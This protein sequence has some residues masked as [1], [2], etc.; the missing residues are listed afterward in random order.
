MKNKNLLNLLS[1]IATLVFVSCTNTPQ[2]NSALYQTG[3]INALLDGLYNGEVNFKQLKE[4]GDFGIGTFNTLDGEMLGFDGQFYQVKSDG[5]AY[6]VNDSLKTPFAVVT[7]FNKDIS[8]QL[9]D[10]LN[11]KGLIQYLDSKIPT[12]NIFYAIKIQGEFNY[13]KTRSVPKQTKP[14][15]TLVTVV[16]KQSTFT[17][18]NVKGTLVGFRFP[19]YTSGINVP[20]YHFHFITDDKLKGGHL[21]QLSGINATVAI[22]AIHSIQLVLPRNSI[23][24]EMDLSANKEKDLEKVEK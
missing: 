12:A 10:T 1:F 18:T 8:T 24:Y 13:I 14:Y 21:L 23:F 16:A 9:R 6:P 2:K 17:F 20:G 5:I 22:D 3:T 7:H 11:Y 4:K 19:D 15:P